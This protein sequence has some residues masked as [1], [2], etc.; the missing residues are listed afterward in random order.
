VDF[1]G[2]RV[3]VVEE[4]NWL[5]LSKGQQVVYGIAEMSDWPQARKEQATAT[6]EKR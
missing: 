6:L 3:V 5:G 4:V 2:S 1:A